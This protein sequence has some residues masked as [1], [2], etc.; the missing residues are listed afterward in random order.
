MTVTGDRRLAVSPGSAGPRSQIHN[1]PNSKPNLDAVLPSQGAARFWLDGEVN[2][3]G[4]KENI[5]GNNG[6]DFED[7]FEFMMGIDQNHGGLLEDEEM[8]LLEGPEGD[9]MPLGLDEVGMMPEDEGGGDVG[10]DATVA[11]DDAGVG[12]AGAGTTVAVGAAGTPRATSSRVAAAA[13]AAAA[14]GTGTVASAHQIEEAK[15]WVG[16]GNVIPDREELLPQR[17]ALH[18]T[19]RYVTVK[20]VNGSERV[21]APVREASCIDSGTLAAALRR[22]KGNLLA[23]KIDDLLAAVEQDQF[24]R[25]LQETK[26]EKRRAKLEKKREKAKS[27]AEEARVGEGS[28]GPTAKRGEGDVEGRRLWVEKYAPVGFLDLLSDELINREV[29]KWVKTWD[30][31]VF[32]N[33]SGATPKAG[34]VEPSTNSDDPLGRPEQKIILLA[35]PPGLGKTTLAHI[36]AAHC[37][38]KPMEINASDE[39]NGPALV[40][41]VV[42]AMEMTSVTSDKRPNCII[43]DEIDGA[44]GGGEGRS[45]I[46]ALIKLAQTKVAGKREKD[47]KE[48]DITSGAGAEARGHRATSQNK[49]AQQ[50]AKPLTRPVICICN[51]LYAPVLR[52]LRDIAKV[53]VVKPPRSEKLVDRLQTICRREKLKADKSTLRGLVEKT[54]CDIRS[55]LNT[56]QFIAKKQKT[57]KLSDIVSV[58]AGQK[59]ISVGV[60]RIWKD[61]L[62]LRQGPSIIGKVAE[63]DSQRCLRRYNT[64]ADFGDQ[65][66]VLGGIFESLP[67]IILFDMALTKTSTVLDNI[68]LMDCIQKRVGRNQEFSL[69]K[70][71]PACTLRVAGVLAGPENP[72]VRWPRVLQSTRKD[73]AH[74]SMMI[75]KWRLGMNPE[76]YASLAKTPAL[77]DVLPYLPWLAA[78]ALRP[79]SRHLYSSEERKRL[80]KVVD[81]M[82]SLGVTFSLEDDDGDSFAATTA[83]RGLAESGAEHAAP[84]RKLLE[85]S[86]PLHALW[87]FEHA[88]FIAAQTQTAPREMPMPTRQMVLHELDMERIKRN[89]RSQQEK[90]GVTSATQPCKTHDGDASATK[91]SQ[92]PDRKFTG[93]VPT[94]VAQRLEENKRNSGTKQRGPPRPARKRNWLDQLKDREA[95]KESM[96]TSTQGVVTKKPRA[97]DMAV[98]YKFHEGYTNAVRKPVKIHDLL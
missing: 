46:Q 73:I 59:D 34:G 86:P 30:R 38:Y 22:S 5:A 64:L 42:S 7:D 3:A 44:S 58:G 66:L 8:G 92:T 65:D 49:A 26:A 47:T 97:E 91:L 81:T 61:L 83:A 23:T 71:L 2:E 37:G 77:L 57:M 41:K 55:C 79:V 12:D 45:A 29:V 24:E 11:G 54:E 93:A 27:E 50:K 18:A 96:L 6:D 1:H 72:S 35:G 21:Y 48:V 17:D 9:M 94:T 87:H 31:C 20:A 85:F 84:A 74:R 68:Q 78:P 15:S 13:A 95:S 82:L 51:D 40:S 69:L 53:F 62:H 76:T 10:A 75:H 36:V 70:Y 43:I 19:D 80:E 32:G 56:M 52:P 25:V 4:E 90:R 16:V 67:S 60:F 63:S 88:D 33:K 14:T 28:E 89:A 98:L 39:R